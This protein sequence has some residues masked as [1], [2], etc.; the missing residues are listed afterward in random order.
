MTLSWVE[1]LMP[2]SREPRIVLQAHRDPGWR[3][4]LWLTLKQEEEKG[5][6]HT[7]GKWRVPLP[8][9]KEQS[10]EEPRNVASKDGTFLV[11]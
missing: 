9:S 2:F 1:A 3:L 11:C 7:L 6:G 10:V 8:R 4:L 5:A